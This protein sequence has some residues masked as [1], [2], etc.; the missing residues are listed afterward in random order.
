MT[1]AS[2][3]GQRVTQL[4]F[5]TLPDEAV[6]SAKMAILD[7]VGVTLAGSL[8]P[9][10][11]IVRRVLRIAD[12]GGKALIFGTD[13]RT[14][15]LN[16]SLVNGTASHVLDFDDCSNT[17]GG[18]PSVP[19]LA[20][21]FALADE[22]SVSGRD[23]IVAYVAGYE[24]E[25][26]VARG[27]NF[28]H[29][30]K[31]W[32]PTATLGTFGAAAA[33]AKLLALDAERISIALAL[34]VSM[35]AGVK[36]NFGTMT[37][38][39]HVGQCSRNGVLAA[40][41]ADEGFT[42]NPEAF[43]HKQGF[44]TVFNGPRDFDAAKILDHWADPLDIIKPGVAIKQYPCCGSTHPAVDA[45]IEIHDAH[46]IDPDK[47]AKVVVWVHPRRLAH[48][49]RPEPHSA[50]EAKFSVQYCA[51]RA[52]MHGKVTLEHFQGD[53]YRD[54]DVVRLLQRVQA[55]PY[56]E[57]QFDSAN[58]FGGEA[59][60]TMKDGRTYCAKVDS[61]LGRTST[62]PIPLDRLRM[63]FENCAG[64]ALSS[65][66]IEKSYLFVSQLE[67]LSDMRELTSIMALG[68]KPSNTVS[69]PG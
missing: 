54:P 68:L 18:H 52:L 17:M 32:H 16:A 10:P 62:N 48:T 29:Y 26:R 19:I 31:G 49:N 24:T 51:A 33:S 11:R 39:F 7:A 69:L 46:E 6:Y 4:Q 1:I 53:A 15:S 34:G 64:R 41:L 59:K 44:L 37:K 14:S 47:V 3:L 66:A 12:C 20:A 9:A 5:D 56:T 25:T 60:V 58:H 27:V 28:Y 50:L 36:A 65:A 45:M 42:A 13:H 38:S 35:A 57:K 30:E 43:E 22:R 67:R 40:L 8:E 63:K 61:A 21:L 2:E 23:F 55:A